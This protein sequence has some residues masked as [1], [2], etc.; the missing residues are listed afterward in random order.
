MKKTNDKKG[1]TLIALIITI[2][3]LLILA[4]VALS[5]L[6]GG[7]SILQ[8]GKL[9][10]EQSL[11]AQ[12][13]EIIRLALISALI[14]EDSEQEITAFLQKNNA[15]YQKPLVEF[16]NSGHIFCIENNKNIIKVEK[17]SST[18]IEFVVNASNE[19]VGI[20][21]NKDVDVENLIIPHTTANGKTILAINEA[22]N[23]INGEYASKKSEIKNII[24]SEGIEKIEGNA[25]KNQVTLENIYLPTTLTEIE[26]SAFSG[27]K[28]K[29]IELPENLITIGDSCFEQCTELTT[30]TIPDS[31][32]TMGPR[33]FKACSN[34]E[35]IV[36]GNGVTTI[37]ESC[38]AQCPK[39]TTIELGSAVTAIGKSPSWDSPN[40]STI[41]VHQTR[42]S[43]HD[44]WEN[45]LFASNPTFIFD[46]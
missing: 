34:I 23:N 17:Y 27:L 15:I 45:G 4:G 41:Y 33:I 1:I 12:E 24:I 29:S 38:F 18:E 43:A 25:F 6:T 46:N 8:N 14:A 2:I 19:L 28:I 3:V 11:I 30:L 7:D 21:I 22:L 35:K 36:I 44:A 13:T 31:V 40:L 16:L 10:T 20:N 37:G 26:S 39:L 9:A 32:T 5:N 42:T